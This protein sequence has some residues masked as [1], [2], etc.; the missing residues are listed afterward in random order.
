MTSE[1]VTLLTQ[2]VYS[3]HTMMESRAHILQ[4]V[5]DS[6][7]PSSVASSD[8]TVTQAPHSPALEVRNSPLPVLQETEAAQPTEVRSTLLFYLDDLP[9]SV[10]IVPSMLSCAVLVG[11]VDYI[12]DLEE[13]ESGRLLIDEAVGV[14]DDPSELRFN[15]RNLPNSSELN[16]A[17]SG[18]HMLNLLAHDAERYPLRFSFIWDST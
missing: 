6:S 15:V 2:Q 12:F 7:P 3:N 1:L 18:A 4:L 13:A 9:I 8:A 5:L 16:I 11:K 10:D 14:H 17:G